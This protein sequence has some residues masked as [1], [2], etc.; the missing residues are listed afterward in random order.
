MLWTPESNIDFDERFQNKLEY[1]NFFQLVLTKSLVLRGFR[2]TKGEIPAALNG[3]LYSCLRSTKAQRR[4]ILVNLLRQFD[5]A[6][7][8]F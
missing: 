1:D 2:E 5:V 4:A 6:T 3:F 7:V 8:S